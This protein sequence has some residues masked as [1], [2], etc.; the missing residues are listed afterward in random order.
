VT[1]P[2]GSRW[3]RHAARRVTGWINGSLPGRRHPV[4]ILMYHSVSD[5][6]DLLSIT[7]AAFRRQMRFVSG[8]HAVIRLGDLPALL[9]RDPDGVRR[10]VITFDDAYRDFEEQALP[11]LG[12][13]GLPATV[14]VPT[15]HIGGTNAWIVDP[16]W[17]AEKPLMG[18][19]QLR[20]V[21]ATGLID[22][23]SHTMQHV[24]M[25]GVSPARARDEAVQSKRCLEDLLGREVR[26]FAYPHGQLDDFSRVTG[27]ILRDA[28]YAM[29]V[30]THWGTFQ[31]A[32]EL[33]ALRRVG[34]AADASEADIEAVIG[35]ADDWIAL[36]ERV[37]FAARQIRA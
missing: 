19:Q 33:L 34:L 21:Q 28:G 4:T 32:D 26:A 6:A 29:A 11:V 15:A 8:R 9:A 10:V 14:F 35:G 22:F 12:E 2:F 16:Q 24:R 31:S 30:T 1:A 7:P 20:D 18:A 36:K 23:G 5:S 27:E 25:T 13:L 17:G 37:G 3:A